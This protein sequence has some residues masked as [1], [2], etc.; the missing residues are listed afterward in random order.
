M[1]ENRYHIQIEIVFR[2]AVHYIQIV[3]A[4]AWR[5]WKREQETGGQG[6]LITRKWSSLRH[7]PSEVGRG[8]FI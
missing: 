4:E 2:E 5:G 3:S 1:E 6:M 8:M 7:T